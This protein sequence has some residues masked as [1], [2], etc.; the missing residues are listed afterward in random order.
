MPDNDWSDF[1]D[2]GDGGS[3]G[4]IDD[5]GRTDDDNGDN[6]LKFGDLDDVAA[7]NDQDEQAQAASAVDGLGHGPDGDLLVSLDTAPAPAPLPASQPAPV[8]SHATAQVPSAAQ[9]SYTSPEYSFTSLDD[10]DSNPSQPIP[11]ASTVPVQQEQSAPQPVQQYQQPVPRQV[12]V[13]KTTAYMNPVTSLAGGIDVE[14]IRKIIAI[15]DDY[16]HLDANDQSVLKDFLSSV[17]ALGRSPKIDGAEASV[18]KGVI[19]IDD[20]MRAGVIDLMDSKNKTGADRAFYLMSLD[21]RRFSNMQIIMQ[22]MQLLDQNEIINV[23]DTLQSI[24]TAAEKMDGYL[25]ERF[26]G[27]AVKFLKPVYQVFVD[28]QKIMES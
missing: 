28:S 11:V 7:S 17:S 27:Q 8:Q 26:Q 16:R 4:V 10:I 9:Q 21:A 1:L 18:V 24:R 19:E 6:L 25:N 22:M 12:P 3:N 20:D 13:M 2:E 5:L 14:L 23:T 15:I